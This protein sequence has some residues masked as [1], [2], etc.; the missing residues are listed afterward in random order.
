MSWVSSEI[1]VPTFKGL[2]KTFELQNNKEPPYILQWSLSHISAYLLCSCMRR[3]A[4]FVSAV[5]NRLPRLTPH[6]E[7]SH[8]LILFLIQTFL[9]QTA[10][11]SK[12]APR[13]LKTNIMEEMVHKSH[14]VSVYH[15]AHIFQA[16]DHSHPSH[17]PQVES[18][19]V[20]TSPAMG[21]VVLGMKGATTTTT[22]MM[23]L[24]PDR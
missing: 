1:D 7:S 24:P 11:M 20:R 5:V 18:H 10:F 17:P 3:I 23:L 13:H 2:D 22:M 8:H 4:L 15:N 16:M 14:S 12:W 9:I 6:H 19:A 21:T